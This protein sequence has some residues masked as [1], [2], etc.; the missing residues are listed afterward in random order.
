MEHAGRAARVAAIDAAA[1]QAGLEVGMI[2]SSAQ[3]QVPALEW[4]PHDPRADL[5]WLDQLALGFE[6]YTAEVTVSPAD[7]L[8]LRFQGCLG[9]FPS[10]R[11]LAADVE[12]RLARRGLHVRCAFAKTPEAARALA[13]YP[14]A[15]APDEAGAIRR[16]PVAAL[17]LDDEEAGLMAEAG[18]RTVGDVAARPPGAISSQFGPHV[19][20]A[21]RR[22]MATVS[23]PRPVAPPPLRVERRSTPPLTRAD[24]LA[25]VVTDLMAEARMLLESRRQVPR[26]WQLTLFRGDGYARQSRIDGGAAAAIAGRLLA[27]HDGVCGPADEELGY[28]LIRL[29]ALLVEPIGEGE[30]YAAEM[31]PQAD[32]AL[33]RKSGTGRRASAEPSQLTLFAPT[34]PPVA[35]PP[36]CPGNM[37][38]RPIHLFDPPQRLD[39]VVAGE[40]AGTPTSFRW[41]RRYHEVARADGPE[42]VADER[43]RRGLTPRA[44]DYYRLQ[45]RRGRRFWIF[46]QVGEDER[47][48]WFVH[49]LFA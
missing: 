33:P 18:L 17:D 12:N 1:A 30:L 42:Q 31:A 45:D 27:G 41:R 28:D 6:R 2:F 5:D 38:E 14:G 16:L 23:S 43:A 34:E 8:V 36:A 39:A 20:E 11:A 35:P 47:L 46:R 22:L 21:V 48:Q 7:A 32:P 29:D 25:P 40:A 4:F 10:E 15:A 44:R 26:R 13:R 37:A 24:E 9:D 49:G 3:A 19:T